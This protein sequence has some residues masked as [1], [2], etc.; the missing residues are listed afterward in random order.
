MET[1]NTLTLGYSTSEPGK[2][3]C[4]PINSLHLYHLYFMNSTWYFSDKRLTVTHMET[5]IYR[6]HLEPIS[7]DT[8]I[9][10]NK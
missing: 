1:F 7:T 5:G 10:R 8:E 9:P 3:Q 6:F 4:G 2:T